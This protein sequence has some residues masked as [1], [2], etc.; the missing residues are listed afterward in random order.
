MVIVQAK[1]TGLWV[2]HLPDWKFEHGFLRRSDA[3]I[4]AFAKSQGFQ[5]SFSRVRDD[6]E[7]DGLHH[8]EDFEDYAYR[9]PIW[10][11]R[12]P[13]DAF[14]QRPV[15]RPASEA[16]AD[17]LAARAV[18]ADDTRFKQYIEEMLMPAADAGCLEFDQKAEA[19]CTY[20]RFPVADLENSVKRI[21]AAAERRGIRF[22]FYEFSRS[23][24]VCFSWK[25]RFFRTIDKE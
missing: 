13:K 19:V 20:F 22:F 6:D 9:T 23:K 4:I 17:E 15:Q 18:Q 16:L 12:W 21:R 3:T 2:S 25:T 7:D 24:L 1:F 5:A 10:R 14:E 11:F 8:D